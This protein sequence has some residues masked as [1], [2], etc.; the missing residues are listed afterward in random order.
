MK[1]LYE[2]VEHRFKTGIL[3]KAKIIKKMSPKESKKWWESGLRRACNW[4]TGGGG[5]RKPI[6]GLEKNAEAA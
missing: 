4:V 1:K 5:N 3:F 2:W 6:A